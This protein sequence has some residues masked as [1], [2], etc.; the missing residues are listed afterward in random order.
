MR[1][2]CL[3]FMFLLLSVASESQ[4]A[5]QKLRVHAEVKSQRYCDVDEEI[6]SL[7]AR[8]RISLINGRTSA[9]LVSREIYPLLLV[10]RSLYDAR[11][12]KHEF[13]INPPDVFPQPPPS[14]EAIQKQMAERRVV[15]PGEKFEAETMEGVLLTAKTEHYSKLEALGPGVHW[16]QLVMTVNDEVTGA[17][18]NAISQPV[19]VTVEQYPKS[20]KCE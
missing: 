20:E 5:D 1:T 16:V 6:F 2:S 17:Y 3:A 7:R 9:V 10:S 12:G 15:Q 18:L 11:N 14:R 4:V 13:E 19:K 8:F